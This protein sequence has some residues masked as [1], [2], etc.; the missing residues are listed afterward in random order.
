MDHLPRP[1][2]RTIVQTALEGTG[3]GAG[4][5]AAPV[6]DAE[7]AIVAVAGDG[8]FVERALWQRT[9]LG[10]GLAGMVLQSG[11]PVALVPSPGTSPDPWAAALLGREPT[12][13]V[14]VPCHDEDQ[15]AGVLQL[16][17]RTGGGPFSFDDVELVTLLAQIAGTALLEGA[18]SS[19]RVA[20]PAQLG[21]ELTRL[22]DADP[23]RYAAV[24]QAVGALLAQA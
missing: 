13:V 4:W 15:L 8:A 11:Q 9:P 14:C 16:V 21:S 22:A 2:L 12:S 24:A 5:L 7:L 17:D 3:A 18:G 19:A 1:L 10:T 20:A 23:V 6:D